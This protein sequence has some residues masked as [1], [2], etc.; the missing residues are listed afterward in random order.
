MRYKPCWKQIG[1]TVERY[2]ELLYF[3]RQYPYWKAEADIHTSKL[4]EKIAIVE[5]CA[6]LVGNGEY[7][8]ALIEHVCYKTPWNRI[9]K[10]LLPTTNSNDFYKHRRLFYELLEQK[11]D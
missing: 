2:S 1:I 9:D 10:T 8:N 5:E 11:K 3:C 7:Y 4:M 6:K